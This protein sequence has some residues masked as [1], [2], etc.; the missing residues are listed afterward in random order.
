MNKITTGKLR[1][2]LGA[3]LATLAFMAGCAS[4]SEDDESL[5]VAEGAVVS[6][7]PAGTRLTCSVSSA[8]GTGRRKAFLLVGPDLS[9][10]YREPLPG[11]IPASEFTPSCH[12]VGRNIGCD[13]VTTP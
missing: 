11:D 1:I 9:T 8:G 6:T 10:C 5:G 4:T 12:E 2:G 7:V 13:V 3:A